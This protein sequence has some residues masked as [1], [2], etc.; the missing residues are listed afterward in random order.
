MLILWI[1]NHGGIFSFSAIFLNSVPFVWV[2]YVFIS[3]H[4]Q[5]V[6][7]LFLNLTGPT[8]HSVE[9]CSVSMSLWAFC[10]WWYLTLI[11]D[12]LIRYKEDLS[13]LYLLLFCVQVCGQF[14][15]K[16]SEVQRRRYIRLC[17]GELFCKYLLA[18]FVLGHQLAPALLCLVFV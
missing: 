11:H 8:F 4:F 3:I 15:R 12:C 18:P 9:S 17:L 1:H 10:C 16:F 13:F 7:N 5:D 14:L 2:C 6:F